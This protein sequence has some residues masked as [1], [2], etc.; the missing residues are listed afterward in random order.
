[1]NQGL[2]RMVR[3]TLACCALPVHMSFTSTVHV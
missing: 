3:L 1:M 2:L